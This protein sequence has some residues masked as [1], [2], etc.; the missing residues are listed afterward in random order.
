MEFHPSSA[1][2]ERVTHF[3]GKG[4][5]IQGAGLLAP[6][7]LGAFLGFIGVVSG[8]LLLVVLFHVGSTAAIT[9]R[10]GAC[11][12]PLA[13][14]AVLICPTCHAVFKKQ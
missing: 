4:C 10:C 8:I 5:L 12:N 13:S 11:R 14:K 9:W 6:F 7:V 2:R 1:R 3:M